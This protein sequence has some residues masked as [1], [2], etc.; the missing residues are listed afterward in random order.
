LDDRGRYCVERIH[1]GARRMNE[2]IDSL[3]DL[4]GVTRVA[5]T[6]QRVDLS[7]LTATIVAE[8]RERA[9]ERAVEVRIA[10]GMTADGDPRL[11]RI[12]LQN[13]LDNAWKYTCRRAVA[14][15]EVGLQRGDGPP[16]YF[17]RDDGAGFDMC[18][19]QRLFG[20]FQ[21]LHADD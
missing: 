17:V 6:R 18:H 9:P 2:L 16:V 15:I 19:A 21:R 3:L 11:L 7:E 8:L 5:M 10:D 20:A 13:L 14:H 4:S 1:E 12:L